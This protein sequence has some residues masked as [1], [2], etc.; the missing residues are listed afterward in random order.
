MLGKAMNPSNETRKGNVIIL[1][2]DSER[3]K[4]IGIGRDWD[5]RPL[6]LEETYISNSLL[7]EIGVQPAMGER[8]HIGLDI[9]GVLNIFGVNYYLLFIST[10]FIINSKFKIGLKRT[11][12]S[13]YANNGDY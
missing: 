9:F 13:R 7:R 1:V 8:V 11:K 5:K 4:E 6:G 12:I 2:I 3:E 10:C